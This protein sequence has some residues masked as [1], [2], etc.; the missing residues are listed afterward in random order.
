[1]T[2]QLATIL[3]MAPDSIEGALDLLMSTMYTESSTFIGLGQALGGLGALMYIF[4]RVWGHLARNEEIDVFPLFRPVA[5]ALCLLTYGQISGAIVSLS[6]ALDE[7]TSGLVTSKVA[8]VEGL[9]RQKDALL[10]QK[11][12]AMQAENLN[13]EGELSW[14][15]MMAGNTPGGGLS[16]YIGSSLKF[17]MSKFFDEALK[18]LGEV[19]YNV[20]SLGIKFL[21]TFFLLVMLI[22][23]P[24]TMGL[25]CFEWFYTGLATWAARVIHLLMWLPLV[26][27]LAGMLESIHIVML[28]QD[29]LQLTNTPQ[30]EFAVIDFGLIAF[31]ILG[32]AGYL[33]IPQAASW[34]V[35]STGAGQAISNVKQG[36]AL[37]GAGAGAAGGAAAGAVKG[38]AN[39]GRK[40]A[41]AI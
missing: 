31:Y 37:Q 12:R 20:A 16:A 7:G 27:L 36:M 34:I 15:D 23:G 35:E 33:M 8:T 11:Y 1:M 5:L 13:A 39:M 24:I 25:A 14:Y 32:T 29:I 40:L 6:K 30:D 2:M 28:R 3:L 21:Q 4:Y 26:N 22:T 9:N 41:N 18:M 10:E 19:L 38:T 17:Y